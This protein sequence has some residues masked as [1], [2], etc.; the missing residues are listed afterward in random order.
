MLDPCQTFKA[1]FLQQCVAAG[2]TVDETHAVVKQALATLR[3]KQASTPGS[4]VAG[5]GLWSSLLSNVP[6]LDTASRL[7]GGAV[8]GAASGVASRVL[9]WGTGLAVA[10][11][12]AAGAATGYGLSQLRGINDASP[13]EVKTQETIDAYRHA[14]QRAILQAALRR[15]RQRRVPSRPML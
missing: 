2:L 14:A 12:I 9:P 15:Q 5:G 4:P 6:G 11:P 13:E 1:S 7:V 3:E 8:E 10:A